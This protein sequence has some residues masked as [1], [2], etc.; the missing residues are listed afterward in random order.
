MKMY[1]I[2]VSLVVINLFF[3]ANVANGDFYS[4]TA[5]LKRLSVT[6]ESVVEVINILVEEQ[7]MFL[8]YLKE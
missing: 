3:I 1:G 6:H 5:D 4:S 8:T 7:E 2:K